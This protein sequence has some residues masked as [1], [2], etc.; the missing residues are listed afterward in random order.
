M[1]EDFRAG[2]FFVALAPITDARL[3]AATIAQ[4]LG[5]AETPGRSIVIVLKDYLQAK[6][7]CYC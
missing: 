1:I 7:C 2:V 6:I 3:V 5:L 4:A